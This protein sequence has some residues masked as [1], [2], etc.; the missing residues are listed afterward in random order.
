[1]Y[2]AIVGGE[3]SDYQIMTRN[4]SVGEYGIAAIPRWQPK[5]SNCGAPSR[6]GIAENSARLNGRSM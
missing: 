4:R 6:D 2:G 5:S 1:M 3:I